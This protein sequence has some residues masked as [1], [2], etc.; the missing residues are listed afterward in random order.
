[1][2]TVK[3]T[4]HPI[5]RN[6]QGFQPDRLSLLAQGYALGDRIRKHRPCQGRSITDVSERTFQARN[7]WKSDTQGIAL[8]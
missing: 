1:M 2:N 5:H 8:G 4:P 7:P 6:A 3:Q